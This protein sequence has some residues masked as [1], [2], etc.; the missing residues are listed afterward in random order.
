M[1][2]NS[3]Y[4]IQYSHNKYSLCSESKKNKMCIKLCQNNNN[5]LY[6]IYCYYYFEGLYNNIHNMVSV[7]IKNYMKINFN[8]EYLWCIFGF[9]LRHYTEQIYWF[10]LLI[11]FRWTIIKLIVKLCKFKLP[12]IIKLISRCQ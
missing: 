3:Q 11:E 10:N 4:F 1:F 5:N 8:Y 6:N 2:R 9:G 12:A 7:I